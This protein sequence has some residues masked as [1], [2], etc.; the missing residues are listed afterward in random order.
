MLADQIFFI[1]GETPKRRFPVNLNDPLQKRYEMIREAALCKKPVSEVCKTYGL[2]RDMYYYYRQKFNEGGM[3]ALKEEKLGP[4]K[5]SKRTEEL[6]NEIIS[7]RF[8]EPELN[9]YQLAYRLKKAGH[10][11]SPRSISRVLAGHGL[12]K[13]KLTQSPGKAPL[14]KR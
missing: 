1:Q 2:S 14:E 6:E 12:T 10:D 4:Q 9:I 11:I 5:P 13:K 3:D 8:E 7:L